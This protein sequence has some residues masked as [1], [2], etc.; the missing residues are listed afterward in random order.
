MGTFWAAFCCM[1]HVQ[2][3]KGQILLVYRLNVEQCSAAYLTEG[4][5]AKP[6]VCYSCTKH[7]MLNDRL[8][9]AGTCLSA[10]TALCFPNATFLLCLLDP[11]C[12]YGDVGDATDCGGSAAAAPQ[13][14]DC[15]GH[16]CGPAHQEPAPGHR[17][18]GARHPL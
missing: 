4:V 15:D 5:A 13:H 1:T 18:A 14:S 11:R 16:L 9:T 12:V 17:P 3:K 10:N 7:T 2:A 6:A 8:E